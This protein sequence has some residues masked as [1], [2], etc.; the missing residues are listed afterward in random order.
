MDLRARIITH[1]EARHVGRSGWLDPPDAL[2]HDSP[3][4]MDLSL[5]ARKA[6]EELRERFVAAGF[7]NVWSWPI[8]TSEVGDAADELLGPGLLAQME[9]R[10]ELRLTAAGRTWVLE[11]RGLVVAFCP[12][13][14]TDVCVPKKQHAEAVCHVCGVRWTE[15]TTRVP[16]VP[17][18]A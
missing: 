12:K 1:R 17:R 8:S 4:P 10:P 11:S 3:E 15:Y 9:S 16:F 18:Y 14:S 6:M 5:A 7:P 13:C 2:G